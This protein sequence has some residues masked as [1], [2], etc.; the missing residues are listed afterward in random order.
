MNEVNQTP[1]P[2]TP[3]KAQLKAAAR[4]RKA[5]WRKSPAGQRHYAAQAEARRLR[6]ES[7]AALPPALADK[8]NAL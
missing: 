7:H 5:A 8:L 4:A 1:R 3:T 2:L 6:S